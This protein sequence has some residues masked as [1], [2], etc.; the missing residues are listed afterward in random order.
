MMLWRLEVTNAGE[1][2]GPV[3]SRLWARQAKLAGGEGRVVVR[4]RSAGM[5]S[6][7]ALVADCRLA[8]TPPFRAPSSTHA[9]TATG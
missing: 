1:S 9:S 2:L 8:L 6:V 5:A 4:C 3:H 7:A